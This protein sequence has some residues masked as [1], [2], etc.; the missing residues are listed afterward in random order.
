MSSKGHLAR[1]AGCLGL[2][3]MHNLG[4]SMPSFGKSGGLAGPIGQLADPPL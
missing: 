1:G 3:N 4:D 2:Q